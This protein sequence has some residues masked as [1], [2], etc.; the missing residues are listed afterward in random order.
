LGKGSRDRTARQDSWYRIPWTGK[1]GQDSRERAG[2]PGQENWD[3]KVRKIDRIVQP[4]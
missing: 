3:R 2:K 4:G 1:P